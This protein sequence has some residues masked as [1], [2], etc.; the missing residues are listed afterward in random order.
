A[1]RTSSRDARNRF[2]RDRIVATD[3]SPWTPHEQCAD[4]RKLSRSLHNESIGSIFNHE[5][6]CAHALIQRS[7]SMK[8]RWAL[9]AILAAS[10]GC[11]CMHGHKHHEEDEEDEKN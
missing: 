6:A 1:D 7:F 3:A 9:A 8:S 4:S 11:H 10:V 2:R 5:R